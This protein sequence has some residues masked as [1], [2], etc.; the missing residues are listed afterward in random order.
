[1]WL[2]MTLTF[3]SSSHHLQGSEVLG[4]ATFLSLCGAK[5]GAQGFVHEARTLPAS[6]SLQPS[7]ILGLRL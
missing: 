2:T 1:M 4:V 5:D 7:F 3:W 6:K